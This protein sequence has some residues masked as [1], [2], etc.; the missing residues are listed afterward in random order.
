M[1]PETLLS[2]SPCLTNGAATHKGVSRLFR[3]VVV[4]DFVTPLHGQDP[5]DPGVTE[6]TGPCTAAHVQEG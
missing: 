1:S 5:Q 3:G 6:R 4:R 2:E